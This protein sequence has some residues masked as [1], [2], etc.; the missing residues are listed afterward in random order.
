V[1]QKQ[2]TLC[3]TIDHRYLDGAQ[4][5]VLARVVRDVL[6]NPWQLEGLEGPPA[7]AAAGS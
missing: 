1:V 4:G 7:E 5:G 2:L 6:E 3:A